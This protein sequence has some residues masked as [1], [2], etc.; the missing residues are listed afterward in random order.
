MHP[1][2]Y[3]PPNTNLQ[4]QR[5]VVQFRAHGRAS[6][7][8]YTYSCYMAGRE[9][10]VRNNVPVKEVREQTAT[11]P[12]G[13][14]WIKDRDRNMW[15]MCPFAVLVD[16]SVSFPTIHIN[17]CKNP[18]SQ[19]HL[20]LFRV[21]SSVLFAA[22][23]MGVSSVQFYI[24]LNWFWLNKDRPTDVTCFIFCSACFEC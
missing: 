13:P 10:R 5:R 12:T 24:A 21:P 22:K 19:P 8:L 11:G 2:V 3:V 15:E 7:A 16:K 4:V 14:Q 9:W 6:R 17:I 23:K 1:K 20:S 18:N